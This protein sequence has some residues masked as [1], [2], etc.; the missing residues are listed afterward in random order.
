MNTFITKII[1]KTF[2]PKSKQQQSEESVRDFLI[3]FKRVVK[4]IF[5]IVCGIICAGFGLKGFLLPNNFIDGGATG[6][7]L[8]VSEL[9]GIDISIL[10]VAINIPFII[11]GSFVINKVF[12]IKTALAVFALAIVVHFL[13]FPHIT[14]DKLL[15]SIFGGF[16]LGAGIG[17]SIRGGSVIDGTEVLAIFLSRKYGVSIGDVIMFVN[18]VIFSFAAYFLSLETAMYAMLTYLAASKTVDFL[19][20]G[21][22]EYF[23][24][25]IIS[26]YPLEIQAMIKEE[27]KR[28][29]T[30]YVQKKGT[31]K[32]GDTHQENAEVVYTVITRLEM[33][34]LNAEIE[35]IDSD[36]FV[37]TQSVKDIKGGMVKKRPLHD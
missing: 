11:L 17:L 29:Y 16:F 8:L 13:P 33:G 15:I 14:T 24:V 1:L 21:I 10:I 4:D 28:G 32:K 23:G 2:L 19:V 37:V 9:S 26:D 3:S 22:E 34:K 5:L 25:T 27:M 7:S 20:E 35:K 31:G 18:V 36:A 6:I 12:A 30:V